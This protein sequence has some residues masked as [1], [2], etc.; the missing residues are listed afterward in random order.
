MIRILYHGQSFIIKDSLPST[1]REFTILLRK[2]INDLP[3]FVIITYIN[4]FLFNKQEN[5]YRDLDY[6]KALELA[7]IINNIDIENYLDIKI[8]N[9]DYETLNDLPIEKYKDNFIYQTQK[10]L[11]NDN[12]NYNDIS[13]KL[14]K[15]IYNNYMIEVKY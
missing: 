4:P 11:L 8:Y 9:I 3:L 14:S 1:F 10:E 15:S 13:N 6:I 5:I 12:K 2:I 7:K